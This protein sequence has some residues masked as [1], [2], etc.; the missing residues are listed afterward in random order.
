MEESE[1][2]SSTEILANAERLISDAKYLYADGRS[3]S[4]AT[5][6]V[7]ALEQMGEYV[8]AITLEKYP[9]AETLMGLF[10]QRPDRH[11]TRQDTLAGDGMKK[12]SFGTR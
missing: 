12:Q 1:T 3:R 4:A 11:A 8:E 9:N 2:P 10:G 5:L 7:H 6:I